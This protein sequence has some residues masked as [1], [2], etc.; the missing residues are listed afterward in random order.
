[1][2]QCRS[3]ALVGLAGLFLGG[4][5]LPLG[6]AVPQSPP[7]RGAL[8][9][10]R[11]RDL[12]RGSAAGVQRLEFAEML[13]AIVG[14]S[15]MGPGDGWFHPGQSRYDWDWLARRQDA[16]PMGAIT[17]QEFRGPAELFE[18]LDRNHDGTLTKDDFDWSE[19]SAFA[20][21]AMPASRWFR[22]VDTNSNGRISREEW[23]AFFAKASKGKGHLTPDDL[24]EAF[25][26]AP[27]PRPPGPPSKQPQGPS[28][29]V[30][31]RGLLNGELGSFLEGPSVGQRAPNFTLKT[32]DGKQRISLE[33][34]RG[35]KPVVLIFGSFT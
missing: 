31:L 14:G 17:R 10:L 34:F 33:Q 8:D 25:P 13:L 28:A 1:M 20:R 6:A 11:Y 35:K 18:R 15:Q 4:S 26:L 7:P 9:P 23:D 21:Q 5:T 22:M 24:R 16:K 30:L 19:R 12:L 3:L 2:L 32:H 29:E 27:P